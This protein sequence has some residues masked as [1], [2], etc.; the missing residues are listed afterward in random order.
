MKKIAIVAETLPNDKYRSGVGVVVG[1][2]IEAASEAG[3]EVT[4]VGPGPIN[5]KC[6]HR[7][8]VPCI[9]P[10]RNY[11][12]TIPFLLLWA[13]ILYRAFC[14]VDLVYVHSLTPLSV[15]SIFLLS[16]MKRK[17]ALIFHFHTDFI[18]YIRTWIKW[19]WLA[20]RLVLITKKS[21][22]YC[23]DQANLPLAP[24]DH[25]ARKMEDELDLAK[26]FE[27][28][29]APIRVPGL[30]PE[31]GLSLSP[32]VYYSGRVGDEKNIRFL[33]EALVLLPHEIRLVIVG[34][35]EIKKYKKLVSKRW[36]ELL[37]RVVFMG[38][39]PRELVFSFC[40]GAICYLFA[41][42][43]E[44]YGLTVY[45]AMSQGL[46]AIVPEGCCFDHLKEGI[47]KL[48]LDPPE[49]GRVVEL[50]YANPKLASE[51]GRSG[52]KFVLENLS[53]KRQLGK[54]ADLYEIAVRSAG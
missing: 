50:L 47:W 46:V 51:K 7:V 3:W 39:L 13:P 40:Q 6:H 35:G 21:A 34:G 5:Q 32:F 49:W 4:L 42:T 44:S 26:R 28:W 33:F 14:R 31:I 16:L 12:S 43:T 24:T 22:K 52:S 23:F 37:D 48:P 45:E 54:L 1:E 25:F 38:S 9:R 10:A 27:V 20:D 17:P 53:P 30:V 18:L 19:K 29:G 41:S 8:W 11:P 2:S 15:F 36:P